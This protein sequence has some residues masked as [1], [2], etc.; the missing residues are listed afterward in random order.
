[1]QILRGTGDELSGLRGRLNFFQG[2]HC[3]YR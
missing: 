1:L 2:G 3:L